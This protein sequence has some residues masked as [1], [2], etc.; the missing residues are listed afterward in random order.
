[1]GHQ[2]IA[3]PIRE[4]LVIR[5]LRCSELG[6]NTQERSSFML[7]TFD[8][9]MMRF[10]NLPVGFGEMPMECQST[11]KNGFRPLTGSRVTSAVHESG[12]SIRRLV[13]GTRLVCSVFCSALTSQRAVRRFLPRLVGASPILM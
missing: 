4:Q 7:F 10:S 9:G 6:T 11:F 13:T 1:M 3:D 8:L 5:Q 2:W 12:L